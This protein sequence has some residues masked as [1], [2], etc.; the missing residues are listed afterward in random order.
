MLSQKE[1]QYLENIWSDPKHPAAFSG[2]QKLYQ[3][4][5]SEGKFKLGLRTITQFLSNLDAY[6]LQKRV[7]RRFKRSRIIVEGIDS[8]WDGDLMDVRN[9][10]KYNQNYQYILVMQD[11]FSRFI[12]TSPLKRKT[13]SAVITALKSIFAQGRQPQILRTDKGSEFKN[14]WVTEYLKKQ[15]IHQMFTQNE[16]KS[17]FAE[18]SIQNLNNR[19]S[20]MFAHKQ[21]YKYLEELSKIT[22]GIN[23]TPSRPLGGIAPSAVNKTNEDE[24]RLNS[25]LVRTK[26]KL[27]KASKQ[28]SDKKKKSSRKRKPSLYKFKVNDK[29]R[30]THLKTPFLR[31]YSEK[32]TGEIFIVSHRYMRDGIP[33]YKLIDYAN[34]PLLGTYYTQELQLMSN[35]DNKEWKINKILKK[36]T[37]NGKTEVLVSW[38]NWPSKFNSWL[39]KSAIQA[40][41]K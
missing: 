5:K 6:S 3:I 35:L 34:E 27:G 26:T 17:N 19:M 1:K 23:N 11:V 2:P 8:Q 20:R 13:A 25:Y 9:I 38:L 37:I 4:V 36:R 31:E 14:R 24:V 33:V 30:I 15:G 28:N 7:Q 41:N 18:R 10:S 32:W 22:K 21:S 16:T 40:V 39:P 12:F 29:V